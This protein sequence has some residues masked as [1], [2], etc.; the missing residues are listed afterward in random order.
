LFYYFGKQLTKGVFNYYSLAFVVQ[1]LSWP[2]IKTFM[3]LAI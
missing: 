2:L 1:P 3:V